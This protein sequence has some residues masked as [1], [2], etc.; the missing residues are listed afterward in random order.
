MRGEDYPQ[1]AGGVAGHREG[2]LRTA[3]VCHQPHQ[4]LVGPGDPKG[5][6]EP[7]LSGPEAGNR[8]VIPRTQQRCPSLPAQRPTHPGGPGAA[9]C[10]STTSVTWKGQT[11][12]S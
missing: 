9:P 8:P 11:R 2:V 1:G 3:P 4:Q 5:R 6:R 10:S 12:V 7:L